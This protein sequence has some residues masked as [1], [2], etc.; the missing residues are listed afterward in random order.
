M[1]IPDYQTLML[2]LLKAVADGQEH[3]IGDITERLANEFQLTQEERQ[4]LLPSGTQTSFSNRV[5]WA[6]SYL[7]QAGLLETTKRA[8]FKIT[9]RGLSTLAE[10]P[11]RIDNEF[12]FRFPEFVSFRSRSRVSDSV[13]ATAPTEATIVPTQ[14]QTPDEIVRNTVKQIETALKKELLDRILAASPAFFESLI[15]H[16]LLAMGYGGSREDAGQIVGKSGDGGIDGI[17][18]QDSLGLDRVYI[19]AKKYN[20][21]NSV[22]EPEIRAFSGSLGAAKANKGVFVTTSSFTLPAQSFAERHPFRIVL[23]DGD[24]LT[25]LMLRHNVGVRTEE[26]LYLKRVDEDFFSMNEYQT[27][28]IYFR[29]SSNS[30]NLKMCPFCLAEIPAA[31]ICFKS[32]ASY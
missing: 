12:L 31:S 27:A 23:I 28:G 24:Q 2:P 4:Q 7:V 21:D 18:D 9:D 6:K 29:N 26:S 30:L 22:S 25:T 15:V 32:P 3:R 19:Q 11:Q 20:R 5:G 10:N 14:A 17:I 8:H 16:L 13:T 1:P